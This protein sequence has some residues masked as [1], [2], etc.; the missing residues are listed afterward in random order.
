V[1]GASG[2]SAAWNK[3]MLVFAK[4]HPRTKANLRRS[5]WICN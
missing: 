5:H 3:L 2:C 1:R 4:V